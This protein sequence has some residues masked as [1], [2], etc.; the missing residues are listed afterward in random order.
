MDQLLSYLN[1]LSQQDREAF[2]R[3]CGCSVG[4]LRKAVSVK[5]RLGEGLCLRI[6][7]ESAGAVKPESLRP[8]VDWEYM[9]AA[10]IGEGAA[11]LESRGEAASA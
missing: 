11:K 4:Y 2:A 9:R 10:L 7:I 3:R 6:G 1:G 8:D 5:Q